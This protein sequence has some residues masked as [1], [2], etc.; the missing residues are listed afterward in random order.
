MRHRQ[1]MTNAA[2]K[3]GGDRKK[4][5]AKVHIAK[6]DLSLDDATYRDVLSSVAGKESAAD[7]TDAELIA[8]IEHFKSRGFVARRTCGK[9]RASSDAERRY[10]P[11]LR[12]LWLSGYNLGVVN[13]PSD[14]AMAKFVKRQ[15]GLDH[16]RFLHNSA[17]AIRAIEGLKAW[18][19]REAGV[20]WSEHNDPRAAVIV[21]QW[22][23]LHRLHPI[24]TGDG[25]HV[26]S[27][28]RTFHGVTLKQVLREPAD[29]VIDA[30]GQDIRSAIAGGDGAST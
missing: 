8:V 2:R 19:S 4:L 28:A 23:R 6:K 3:Q 14:E 22:S 12:A 24:D 29:D 26:M 20:L 16:V 11:K 18:L 27:L 13:D 30:L 17:D 5:L 15:T 10:L 21:A 9:R 1:F 25:T 7:C